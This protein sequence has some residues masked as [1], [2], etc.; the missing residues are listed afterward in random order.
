MYCNECGA[1]NADTNRFCLKCGA[2]L[3]RIQPPSPA[4]PPPSMAP[5]R[6]DT[7][8]PAAQMPTVMQTPGEPSPP[9]FAPTTEPYPGP[10][11]YAPPAAEQPTEWTWPTEPGVVDEGYFPPVHEAPTAKPKVRRR[12]FPRVVLTCGI[13]ALV[14]ALVLVAAVVAAW[15]WLGL[16]RTNQTVRIIPDDAAMVVSFSP[17]PRQALQYRNVENLEA[18]V[19]MLAAVPGLLDLVEADQAQLAAD[20]DVDFRA[21]ILPW[22]G[23]EASIA[24][25]DVEGAGGRDVPPLLVSLATHNERR[26]SEFL[27]KVQDALEDE[28]YAFEEETYNGVDIVYQVPTREGAFA[29]A[30]A[31]TM[32]LVLLGTDLDTLHTAIDIA[33]RKSQRVLANED[34]YKAVIA[35]LPGNRVGYVYIDGRTLLNLLADQGEPVEGLQAIEGLGA[36]FGLSSSGLTLDYV[37]RYD[38]GEMSRSHEDA[39]QRPAT[40]RITA[41]LLPVDTVAYWSEQ[42]PQ[43]TWEGLMATARGVE[44]LYDAVW[45]VD[46]TLQDIESRTG[47]DVNE[48]L[49]SDFTGEYAL[50]L[51]PDKTGFPGAEEAPLG[52]VLMARTKRP[53]STRS[54]LRDLTQALGYSGMVPS[55]PVEERDITYLNTGSGWTL[56]YGF[57]DDFLVIGSSPAAVDAALEG[58]DDPLAGASLYQEALRR[59]PGK[60]RGYLFAD[61]EAIIDAVLKAV[62]RSDRDTYERDL[63]PYLES[64]EGLGFSLGSMDEDGLVRGTFVV[65]TR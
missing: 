31:T 47:F 35:E 5:T 15:F 56:A 1:S 44:D 6:M 39:M 9:P 26:S 30:F 57:V 37:I 4:A 58:Q 52:L 32:H 54:T 65:L 64:L 7:Y 49:L 33:Q 12:R 3:P 61:A 53:S 63:E 23:R 48:E 50:A 22:I 16:H 17:D 43:M 55:L 51:V 10:P 27:E 25:L 21:D 42:D 24:V 34:A 8:D 14:L 11:A 45:D 19:P 20:L 59:L 13:V 46:H 18:L 41:G 28:G 36:S 40:D 62:S 60:A 38:T 2:T 29:P